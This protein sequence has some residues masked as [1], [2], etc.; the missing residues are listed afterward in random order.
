MCKVAPPSFS[1]RVEDGT[2][3]VTS[4]IPTRRYRNDFMFDAEDPDGFKCP[5][6]AHIRKVNPRGTTP[7]TSLAGEKGVGLPGEESHT[8]AH[9]WHKRRAEYRR[10]PARRSRAAVYVLPGRY[11]PAVRIPPTNLGDN[12]NFPDNLPNGSDTGDDPVI[13]QDRRESQRWPRK[14]GDEG[15]GR[16]RFNF[17]A[18]VTLRGGEYLFAP[19]KPFFERL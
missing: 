1:A 15:Q 3:A 10:R 14:W 2:P 5:A 16:Q 12:P 13:G 11:C 19:S 4:P 7:Q 9:A 17:E 8:A 6:H 18:A